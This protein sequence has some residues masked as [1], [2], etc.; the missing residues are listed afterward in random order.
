M[1]ATSKAFLEQLITTPSP[2]GDEVAVQRV[3]M[4]YVKGFAHQ[5]ETDMIGNVM[6]SVNPDNPFKIMLAGRL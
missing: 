3:W 2:S 5:I 6:A 4:D 1:E